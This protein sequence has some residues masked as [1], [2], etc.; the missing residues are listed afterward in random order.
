M[1]NL[2][3]ITHDLAIGGLQQVVVNICR[4]INKNKF[5]VTVLCLNEMGELATKINQLKIPLFLLPKNSSKPDYL[6]FIKVSRFV[7]EGAFKVIHTHNTQAMIDGTIAGLL[8]GVRKI[9]HTDHARA[10]PDKKRYMFSE[11]FLSHFVSKI[12]GVSDHTCENLNRYEKISR[13]KIVMIPNGIDRKLFQYNF[14]PKLKRDELGLTRKGPI[15]GLGVRLTEQKGII[16]LLRA[17]PNLIRRYAE[18]TLLI[19]GDGPLRQ[20]LLKEAKKLGISSHV[21]FLG[22]RLDMTEILSVLDIYVLPSLWEGLPMVLLEALAVGIPVVATDVGGVSTAIKNGITGLLVPPG[23]PD[24]I[25]AA[26]INLLDNDCLRNSCIQNGRQ[27]FE[28]DFTAEKMV[29]RYEDL[30]LQ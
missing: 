9:I 8:T 11:W 7:R 3:I 18:I 10:F 6:S 23:E 26:V 24:R 14:N 27:L 29:K 12:V 15:I 20:N 22:P 30:Y 19:A 5:N 1:K 28:Q 25:S 2:L 13:K 4:C 21:L 17:M 16:Y